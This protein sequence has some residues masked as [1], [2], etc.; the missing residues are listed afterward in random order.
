LYDNALIAVLPVGQV[1]VERRCA[2]ASKMSADAPG[3]FAI[4]AVLDPTRHRMIASHIMKKKADRP[5]APEAALAYYGWDN[6]TWNYRWHLTDDL[7]LCQ[8][9]FDYGVPVNEWTRRIFRG[10]LDFI[11]TSDARAGF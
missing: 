5:V 3:L 2:G 1:S 4:N 9:F 6:T 7:G 8:M 10:R 11:P